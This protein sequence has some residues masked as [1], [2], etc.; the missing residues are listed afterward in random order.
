[1]WAW[2]RSEK[3]LTSHALGQMMKRVVKNSQFL[4]K[5]LQKRVEKKAA[6]KKTE[7]GDVCTSMLLG[8]A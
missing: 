2:S 4:R 6:G 1:M 3:P 8:T 7:H 5:T